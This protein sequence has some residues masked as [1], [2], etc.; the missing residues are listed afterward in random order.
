MPCSLLSPSRLAVWL[1]TAMLFCS[2]FARA[3][4]PSA[5]ADPAL[6]KVQ[7]LLAIPEDQLDLGKAKLAIDQLMDPKIDLAGALRQLDAMAAQARALAPPNASKRD[8]VVALQTY[9]YLPGSWNGN[10]PFQYDLEDPFGR[11]LRNKLLTTYLT[12]RRGNC[13]SMPLLFIILGQKLGLDVTAAEA[14]EHVLVKFRDEQGQLFN[15]EATSGGFKSDASYRQDMPMTE[16]ALASGVYL[17][18]LSKRETVAVMAGTL[19]EYWGQQGQQERRI[20]LADEVLAASPTSV[21]AMLQKGNAYY[22]MLRGD[23]LDKYPTMEAIPVNERARFQ[24]LGGNNHLWFNRAEALGWRMPT[25][26]QNDAYQQTIQ[27]AQR[28]Q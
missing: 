24:E 15:I 14:P 12:T 13:V 6:Q 16:Q 8:T 5:E 2:P 3:Q 1:V 4:V 10:R 17:R 9:L 11:N 18:R 27:R 21:M 23:F 19:L 26:A 7:H 20:A 28:A 22:R 25:E